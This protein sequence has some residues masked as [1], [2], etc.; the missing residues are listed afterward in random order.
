MRELCKKREVY[1]P[2]KFGGTPGKSRERTSLQEEGQEKNDTRQVFHA[3]LTVNKCQ[4]T[5]SPCRKLKL[6]FL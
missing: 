2:A 3:H 1:V 5:C 6:F 4:R